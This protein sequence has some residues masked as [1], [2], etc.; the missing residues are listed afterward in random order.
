VTAITEADRA[1]FK[2]EGDWT[3]VRRHRIRWSECDM[4]AHVNH[5]AYLILF[6]DLRVAWWLRC[7]GSFGPGEP[8]PAVIHFDVRYLKAAGFDDEV[9]LTQRTP[10]FRRSSFVHE[11]GMWRHDGLVCS[12]RAVCVLVASG[13]GEKVAITPAVRRVMLEVDG[14]KEEGA[15]G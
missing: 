6:E 3:L 14:A 2:V 11:Y 13:S 4:H 7:G 15:G 5:A 12:A 8:G 10:S 9:L 1:A